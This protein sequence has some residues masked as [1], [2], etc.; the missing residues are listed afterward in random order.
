LQRQ[1]APL[2]AAP[3]HTSG[4]AT[5]DWSLQT[6]IRELFSTKK[7]CYFSIN[8]FRRIAETKESMF[9]I[10]MSIASIAPIA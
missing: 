3:G 6:R 7:G 5:V 10:M 2:P 9:V 4:T 8:E 1:P